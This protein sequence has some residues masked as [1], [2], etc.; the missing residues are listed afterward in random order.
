MDFPLARSRR[1]AIFGTRLTARLATIARSIPAGGVTG[2]DSHAEMGRG[3]MD[4]LQVVMLP[5]KRI[6]GKRF[7]NTPKRLIS[8]PE[9]RK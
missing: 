8:A 6:V 7:H 5:D 9:N 2:D 1:L 4:T 3:P